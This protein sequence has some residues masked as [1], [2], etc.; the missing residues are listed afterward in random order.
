M[1]AVAA[2]IS[3]SSNLG[4]L[5]PAIIG[6]ES[7]GVPSPG[8]TALVLAAVLASEG[9]LNIWLVIPIAAASAIIGDNL[10]YFLG[11]HLGRDVLIAAGPFRE[12]RRRLMEIGDRYFAKHGAKTIFIGRWIALIRFAV[13]WLSGINEVPFRVFFVWNALGAISWA[14]TYGLVGYFG[15]NAVAKVLERVGVVAAVALVALA[16]GA[17]IFFKHRERRTERAG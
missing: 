17:W 5:L 9:K 11:R 3:V 1:L 12:R 6:L 7:M 16:V 8:E 4:Y 14:T 10:G 15:G 2:F 13:A